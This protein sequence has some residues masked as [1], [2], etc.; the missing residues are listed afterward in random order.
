LLSKRLAALIRHRQNPHAGTRK[1]QLPPASSVC[2]RQLRHLRADIPYPSD[3]LSYLQT[4][5]TVGRFSLFH[6]FHFSFSVRLQEL[7]NVVNDVSQD[8]GNRS[9]NFEEILKRRRRHK[10]RSIRFCTAFTR[11]LEFER[12]VSFQISRHLHSL[13]RNLRSGGDAPR[14]SRCRPVGFAGSSV[15]GELW[16]GIY[17]PK[18]GHIFY[19]GTPEDQVQ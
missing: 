4:A 18:S 1:G 2:S 3:A 5:I 19:N 12:R 9:T 8:G 10:S 6:L 7:G 16:S 17:R 13:E 11:T 14:P 15:L